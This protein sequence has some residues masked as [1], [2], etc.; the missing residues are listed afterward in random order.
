MWCAYCGV[1][2]YLTGWHIYRARDTRSVTCYCSPD[3]RHHNYKQE[4]I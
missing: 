3:G 1:Q 2:I 4:R